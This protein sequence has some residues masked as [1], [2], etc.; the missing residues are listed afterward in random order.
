MA[1][2]DTAEAKYITAINDLIIDWIRANP[3]PRYMNFSPAWRA[4]EAARRIEQPWLEV[5]FRLQHEAAFSPEA[6]IMFNMSK[7][8]K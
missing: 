4:L 3:V 8:R 5:F 2:L 6:R 7:E 1:W